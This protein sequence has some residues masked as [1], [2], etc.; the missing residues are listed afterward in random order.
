[1]KENATMT[2]RKKPERASQRQREPL[3]AS[4][5]RLL[6]L[7]KETLQ[8]LTEAEAEVAQGGL[9][10][11]VDPRV[12]GAVVGASGAYCGVATTV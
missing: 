1:V 2:Q 12:G 7:N 3:A 9:L 6:E 11:A 10:A 4:Q 5:E 8:D